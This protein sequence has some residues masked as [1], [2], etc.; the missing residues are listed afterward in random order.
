MI[1]EEYRTHQRYADATVPYPISHVPIS[2]IEPSLETAAK[3]NVRFSSDR[4]E[5]SNIVGGIVHRLL[6]EYR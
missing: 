4:E 1:G 3:A 2:G 6:D 5:G